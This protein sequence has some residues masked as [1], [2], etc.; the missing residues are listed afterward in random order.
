VKLHRTLKGGAA[1]LAAASI[2]TAGLASGCSGLLGIAENIDYADAA[3]GEE[4]GGDGAFADH[5]PP[6]EGSIADCGP[7]NLGDPKNCGTCGHNCLGGYCNGNSCTPFMIGSAMIASD[8]AAP[9]IAA[10][11]ASVYWVSQDPSSGQEIVGQCPVDGIG[12]CNQIT[13][14]SFPAATVDSIA[15]NGTM[16]ALTVGG[17]DGLCLTYAGASLSCAASYAAGTY[18]VALEGTN[19]YSLTIGSPNAVSRITLTDYLDAGFVPAS[20]PLLA[21]AES[22]GQVYVL[23]KGAGV[24][25]VDFAGGALVQKAPDPAMPASADLAVT[26]AGF[27]WTSQTSVLTCPIPGCTMPSTVY[28]WHADGLAADSR[29]LYFYYAQGGV[30]ACDLPACANFRMIGASAPLGAPGQL[31]VSPASV[32]WIDA[33]GTVWQWVK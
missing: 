7:G 12:I 28:S 17:N 18:R 22:L 23:E 26:A 10:D 14:N 29:S 16:L 1:V 27:Y 32:F 9:A 13:A 11:D 30:F 33:Q 8:A 31:A 3:P 4:G 21:I 25:V 6:P 2:P 24:Y 20:A 15:T 19:T 5:A